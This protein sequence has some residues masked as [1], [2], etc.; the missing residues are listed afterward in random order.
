MRF[1][2]AFIL[3]LGGFFLVAGAS[4]ASDTDE[5]L[6]LLSDKEVITEDEA[7]SIKKR[8]KQD[9]SPKF[10][11]VSLRQVELSG[12]AQVR[13]QWFEESGKKDTFDARRARLSLKGK[14]G[15]GFSYNFQ[16]EFGGTAQ[17]L[18]DAEIVYEYAEF[19]K[20]SAGQFKIPF[21]RESLEGA[22][23]L[24]T[25]DRSQVVEALVGWS[26]DVIGNQN[27]RDIGV[28]LH[29]YFPV[30]NGDYAV[31]Y[32][33]GAF[34]GA[35]INTADTNEEKDYAGRLVFWPA[36]DLYFGGSYYMGKY[37]LASDVTG[38]VLDRGR[39]GVEF[40]FKGTP[41][42]V[43]GE[44]IQGT[45]NF[46][47]SRGWFLQGGYVL[48][49]GIFQGVLKYDT[50]DPDTSSSGDK[51][52]VYTVGFNYWFNKLSR[53]Q[54]NYEFKKEEGP[55]KANNMASAQLQVGF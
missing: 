55:D 26:R 29:G 21:S 47:E 35:G 9:A 13:Y 18:L 5:L 42:S 28:K 39:T 3:T 32:A 8:L 27:G 2:R 50:Y 10:E 43:K 1:F 31:E 52:D 4:W 46:T 7:A 53:L 48:V 40:G 36:R 49:P 30:S 25:I 12:F 38:K 51:T 41:L 20:L 45:D 6:K 19:L 11:V 44:W 16:E 37:T 34:N 23:K 17:K 33:V 24:E 15:D 54:V 14:M 22:D